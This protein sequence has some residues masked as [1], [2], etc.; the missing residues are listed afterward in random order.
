MN[1]KDSYIH[2][3]DG[4]G[5]VKSLYFASSAENV[6]KSDFSAKYNTVKDKDLIIKL[7]DIGETKIGLTIPTWT[8]G[9][10][11]MGLGSVYTPDTSITA[12]STNNTIPSSKAVWDAIIA[13]I[14][15]NDAMVFK[16]TINGTT[17]SPGTYT[18]QA[19]RGH[20][21]KVATEGYINGIWYNVNDTFICTTDGTLAANS[22]NYTTIRNNWVV[23]E[24]NGD[25]LSINGGTMQGNLKWKDTNALPSTTTA[26]YFLTVS[27]TSNGV[28]KYITKANLLSTLGISVSNKEA[29]IGTSLTTIATINGT[30]ITAKIGSY[31]AIDHSHKVKINNVEKTIQGTTAVDLGTYSTTDKTGVKLGTAG[32]NNITN[33]S[34]ITA[35]SSSGIIFQGATGGFKIGNGTNSITIGV[36]HGLSTKTININGTNYAIYTSESSLPTFIAPTSLASTGG[37]ILATNSG[38]TALEWVSKPTSNVTTSAVVASTNSGT[39]QIST[40]Q[41]DPYYNLLEGGAVTRYIQFKAGSNMTIKSSTSGIITFTSSYTNTWRNIY[42][43]GTSRVGTGT[44]T[45]AMNFAVAGNLSVS[46]LAAGTESGQSGNANYF[47][48]KITANPNSVGVAGYVAA[49]TKAAN[50]NQVWMTNA[51]GEPAWRSINISTTATQLFNS[52]ATLSV[53]EWTTISAVNTLAVGTYAIQIVASGLYASGI[54]SACGGSDVMIDEIVLHVANATSSATWRPY[55][56]ISGNNLE[57]SSNETTGT[58]RT[59]TIKILKLI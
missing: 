7:A 19:D 32:S 1:I 39:A 8:I 36:A 48:I 18:S 51:N 31:A 34:V 2:G 4:R 10:T 21:Y 17:T 9:N 47:T 54:F 42:T 13:G 30:N 16:G 50:P 23:V 46:Y 40:E 15:T 20:T 11:V 52:T 41:S 27:G 59:Y 26:D 38:K 44:G 5:V 58:S 56:R 53:S 12:S 6:W 28:T 43:G 49:P 22:S 14:G 37:Y 45:K 25:Y 35:D 29:T 3:A 33:G 24:G 57:M 55:A